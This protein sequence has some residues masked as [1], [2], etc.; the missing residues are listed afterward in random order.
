M[1][2][3]AGILST[4][5][6]FAA[7][8]C[9]GSQGPISPSTTIA[10]SSPGT[11]PTPGAPAFNPQ[12]IPVGQRVQSTWTEHGAL[13]DYDLT[14]PF[15]GILVVR[16]AWSSDYRGVDLKLAGHWIVQDQPV[17]ATLAVTSGQRYRL[18]VADRYAWD[19]DKIFVEYVLTT[20][21]E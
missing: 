5:L 15:N 2:V 21:M 13:D 6:I 10:P 18:T 17:V 7:S 4:L 19:Y 9:G 20:A 11:P 16:L 1:K 3:S 14:A 12:T 8:A